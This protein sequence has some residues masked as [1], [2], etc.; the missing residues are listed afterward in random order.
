MV[1]TVQSVTL[2]VRFQ[3][4]TL[5]PGSSSSAFLRIFDFEQAGKSTLRQNMLMYSLVILSRLFAA[6]ARAKETGSYNEVREHALRDLLGWTFWFFAASQ[7]QR[8]FLRAF[9]AK[10]RDVLV[11]TPYEKKPAATSWGKLGERLKWEFNFLA[12]GQT[13]T[14]R[15]LEQRMEQFLKETREAARGLGDDAVKMAEKD[16]MK[17]FGRLAKLRNLASFTGITMAIALLGVGINLV[18]IAM[19]RNNVQKRGTSETAKQPVQPAYGLQPEPRRAN[20]F[21]APYYPGYL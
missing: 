5:T 10:Y 18:N 19:T 8:L 16:A 1:R 9:P 15:Q 21:N 17:Y 20:A 3:W 13:P 4:V 12:R 2:P 6:A 11:H 14:A 7:V